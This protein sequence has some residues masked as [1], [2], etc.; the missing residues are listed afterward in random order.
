[1]HTDVESREEA[2]TLEIKH[3]VLKLHY[4]GMKVHKLANKFQLAHSTMDAIL[5]E[6][7]VNANKTDYNM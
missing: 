5:E 2:F 3:E 6:C 1:V 7:K 4:S